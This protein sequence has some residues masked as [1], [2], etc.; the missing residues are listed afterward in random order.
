M[1]FLYSVLHCNLCFLLF[2]KVIGQYFQATQVLTTKIEAI[3]QTARTIGEALEATTQ[4][5]GV[6]P[7]VQSNAAAIQAAE[8]RATGSNPWWI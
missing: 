7:V 4:I 2:F 3:Q 6:K 1:N 5:M 8:M